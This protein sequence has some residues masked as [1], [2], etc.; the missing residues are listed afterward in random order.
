M[1]ILGLSCYY[2]DAAAAL[3]RDGQLIAAG[4]E[5]RFS[6]KKHDF[7]F[8]RKAID[9][10]LAE[11]GIGAG[12][13]DY[14]VFYEKP[15]VKF[16]RILTSAINTWPLSYVT[17]L[18]AIPLWLKSRLRVGKEIDRELD[19]QAPILYLE[20]H[21]SHAGAAFLTSPFERAAILTIDGVG[22]W[23]C[24]TMGWGEG[25]KIRIDREIRFPHSLGLLYSALT[26]YLGFEVNDA[27]WKVMGLAPYGQPRYVE[28]FEK[29][30]D[31]RDDGSF[32]LDMKY[33]TFHHSSEKM[34]SRAFV[35][36]FGQPPRAP[37][38]ELTDFHQDLARSGQAVVEKLILNMAR[39]AVEKYQTDTLCLGGG[40]GLNCVANWKIRTQTPV[41][42]LY[43]QP[44]TGDDGGAVGAALYVWNVLLGKPRT[45]TMDMPFFGPG[46]T[47]EE[48]QAVLR[49]AGQPFQVVS[50]E[51]L[52]ERS[53]RQ[54]EKGR[55]IGW[56]QGR[57]EFGPRAL[58]NRSI[59]ASPRKAEMKDIIN[60]KIKFREYFR[61]FAPAVLKERA[62]EYFELGDV[63]DAPY[64]L[65]APPVFKDKHEV[66]PAVTHADGTG[67]VQTVRREQNPLYYDLIDKV[68]QLS[69]VPVIV[70][71]SF[72]VRGEPI[73]CTPKDGLDTFLK[74]GID[75][76]VMGNTITFKPEVGE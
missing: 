68:G 41:K 39:A 61:P 32:R 49:E 70:N 66:I 48:M 1:H 51:E 12:D 55:V 73:V 17:F 69:G 14:V 28:Q 36:L 15:I 5:E 43:I 26:A 24:A 44:A 31:L 64:M 33:F 74:T 54:V 6:R 63:E 37:E 59:I 45:F 3:V 46:Y 52:L 7:G 19:T 2:H 38:S 25:N 21:L 50:R 11:G 20:H 57:M 34:Y 35:D 10:C 72:N 75:V 9:Y 30:V 62:H 13:L 53:A 29:L 47:D 18:K 16:D 56:F 76:L 60:S 27:E 71:T 65:L 67:R 8:P 23:A 22:E 42:H 40:V 4:A 58:G